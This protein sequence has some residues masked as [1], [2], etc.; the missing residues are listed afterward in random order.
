VFG[1]GG[2][3]GGGKMISSGNDI[4]LQAETPHQCVCGNHTLII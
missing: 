4:A 1:G 2:G 3:G